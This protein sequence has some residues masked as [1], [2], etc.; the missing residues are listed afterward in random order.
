MAVAEVEARSGIA[1]DATERKRIK[2]ATEASA[3]AV[4]AV[5]SSR[6]LPGKVERQVQTLVN[7][8]LSQRKHSLLCSEMPHFSAIVAITTAQ[9]VAQLPDLPQRH[10]NSEAQ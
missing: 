9:A 6:S 1:E 4:E 8:R 2:V 3:V 10:R 7:Q 5:T